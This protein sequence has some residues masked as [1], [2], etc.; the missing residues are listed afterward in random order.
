M[1]SGKPSDQLTALRSGF[2]EPSPDSRVMMR[3]WW[4]GPDVTRA[5]LD[6]ELQ[7]M[8]EAGIGGVEVSY[9]YPLSADSPELLG[10]EFLDHLRYAAERARDLGLRFDLTLGSGWS[11]GGPHID[12]DHAAKQLDWERREITGEPVDLPIRTWPGDR[13][14]AAYLGGGSAQEPPTDCVRLEIA[15]DRLQIPR[16]SGPRQLLLAIERPTGQVV[17]RAAAGADGPVLDHYSA[18]AARAHLDTFAE[19]LLAAVPAE[20]IGS[21]FCDSLEVYG[22]NWTPDLVDEFERRRGYP[23]L[24]RLYELIINTDASDQ[25]RI[26]YYRTL[27]ELYEEN[28][29][30]VFQRWAADHGVRFRIQGYGAPPAKISSYRFADLYEGEG[31]GWQTITQTRWASSAAHLDGLP[32]V[33]AES[34]TWVH[35]PT[36]RA[37][38]LDLLGEAHELLLDGVNQF[39]GHGWPYS[40]SGTERDGLGWFFYAAGALDDRNPWWP[41]MPGLM[42]YLQRLSWLQR[43][44]TPVADIA[45]YVPSDDLYPHLGREVG[46]SLDLWRETNRTV[47]PTIVATIRAGGWD[48]D[49]VDDDAL[50]LIDPTTRPVFIL[51]AVDRLPERTRQW[52]ADYQADG[53]IVLAVE[54]SST[55]G[56]PGAVTDLDAAIRGALAPDL[57]ITPVCGEVGMVHRR[58]AGDVDGDAGA[59]DAYLLINTGPH[60]REFSA[61]PRT[62]H[63]GHELWDPMTGQPVGTF[64]DSSIPIVLEPYQSVVIVS[65]DGANPTSSTVP[66]A[67]EEM[68]LGSDWTVQYDDQEPR[69]VTLPH[70]WEDDRD[71]YSGSA[72]YRGTIELSSD[73]PDGTPSGDPAQLIMDFGELQPAQLG[74]DDRDGIRGR[75]YRVKGAAPIREVAE[76]IINGRTAG[77]V[78]APPYQ[79][80][81]SDLLVTGSN[82]VQIR[83][84]N[85]AA[86][87]LSQ[88]TAI[89]RAVQVSRGQYGQRFVMQDLDRA[90]D[91]VSSG[92][93]TVPKIIRRR[94]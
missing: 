60:R 70:R 54:G 64:S 61:T 69:T 21:V 32:V 66:G 51:P 22:A 39:I 43:Q 26:D 35:S 24:P 77:V 16:G 30:T 57:S 56:T 14:V 11:F 10:P 25:L 80:D 48:Y 84:S 13:L 20:L 23:L 15:D 86:N 90:L 33:S 18:S 19:P 88:D 44:G 89:D 36:F 41:A 50:E 28:F 12:A 65:H 31:W 38:P 75:S 2:A 55:V 87:A 73:Q 5:E 93:L 67:G 82:A 81:L 27:T 78:W 94:R 92:L 17:K 85:T 68:P 58:L 7:V 83:V 34:W 52:L 4:F 76:V 74:S 9:V 37:T 53:G 40:P 45:L 49:L 29:V 62:S 47:D 91:G 8:A 59:V 1:S 42:R 6:R 79:V 46:G 72:V 63:A 71:G 3:W